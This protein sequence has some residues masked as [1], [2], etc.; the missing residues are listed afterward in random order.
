MQEKLCVATAKKIFQTYEKYQK[1]HS[2]QWGE[3]VDPN[4][5]HY[6]EQTITEI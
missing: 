1:F 5:Q 6:L 3:S 2:L 4:G